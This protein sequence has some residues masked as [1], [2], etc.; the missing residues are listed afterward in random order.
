MQFLIVLIIG[1][2]DEVKI[3]KTDTQEND[4]LLELRVV[5]SDGL[6]K[7]HSLS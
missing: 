6:C 5:E 2:V 1:A 3:S 7:F 4:K